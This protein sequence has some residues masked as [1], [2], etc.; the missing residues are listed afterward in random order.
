[1]SIRTVI[2]FK[3]ELH[4]IAPERR[5][6]REEQRE[7]GNSCLRLKTEQYVPGSTLSGPL[8]VLFKLR[9]ETLCSLCGFSSNV[10][11]S[12]SLHDKALQGC[13]SCLMLCI[14]LL[15]TWRPCKE[16]FLCV[17]LFCDQV[18]CLHRDVI[19]M[20]DAFLPRPWPFLQH[21]LPLFKNIDLLLL[22]MGIQS[23]SL[24]E[25]SR[26]WKCCTSCKAKSTHSWPPICLPE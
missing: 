21:N 12:S 22:L 13:R 11:L 25:A 26:T 5:N 6:D 1:M 9:E 18:K 10:G 24:T 23:C 7:W 16:H 14:R 17:S 2:H 4:Y 19:I 3:V 15:C 8:R 20:T